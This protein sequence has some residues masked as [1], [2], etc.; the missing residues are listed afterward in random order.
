MLSHW[1]PHAPVPSNPSNCTLNLDR[2]QVM[3]GDNG[4]EV[5]G[6]GSA[7]AVSDMRESQFATSHNEAVPLGTFVQDVVAWPGYIGT[8]VASSWLLFDNNTFAHVNALLVVPGVFAADVKC[9]AVNT[10]E[11]G[12]PRVREEEHCVLG[13]YPRG[14]ERRP[15]CS[16]TSKKFGDGRGRLN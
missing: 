12:A 5:L 7:R 6:F 16:A 14:T 3:L 11:P 1:R 4:L 8:G 13:P 2:S 10:D 9:L 15:S